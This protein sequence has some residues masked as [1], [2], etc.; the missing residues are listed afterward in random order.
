MIKAHYVCIVCGSST[1]EKVSGSVMNQPTT[2]EEAKKRFPEIK[3]YYC[4]NK[5]EICNWVDSSGGSF[6]CNEPIKNFD[7]LKPE[8]VER[9]KGKIN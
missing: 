3:C 1:N 8:F 9:Y 5:M 4:D 6:M 2:M 7:K